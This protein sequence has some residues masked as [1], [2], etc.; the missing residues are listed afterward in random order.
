MRPTLKEQLGCWL[1]ERKDLELSLC[2][3]GSKNWLDLCN[4]QERVTQDPISHGRICQ[5]RDSSRLTVARIFPR[6]TVRL[7]KHALDQWPIALNFALERP[8]TAS[9]SASVLIAMGGTE[10]IEQ[11]RLVLAAL[12]AQSFPDL[13][14]IVVEQSERRELEAL[15]PKD[16]IYIHDPYDTKAG[17]NKS[18]ALNIAAKEARGAYFLIHDGDYLVPRDY[19][20]ECVRVLEK[21]DG[22]RPGRFN[23]HLDQASTIAMIRAEGKLDQL[24]IEYVV[25]N[26]PTP[27]AARA[28]SYWEIGGHDESFIGWGGEDV[29]FL[30]RLRTRSVSEGGWMPVI[31]LWHPAAP[32]KASGD[33]NQQQQDHLLSLDPL[34]RIRSLTQKNEMRL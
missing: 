22:V 18:R 27:M 26:N 19:A 9:P 29:E 23:F 8:V 4:R 13:E 28:R 11:F 20:A 32:K 24:A 33:R 12:R 5:W 15:L 14:I 17:F 1:H 7:L 10:R 30:S 34:A 25:Q 3:W 21:V 16:V 2:G 31:H 6:A